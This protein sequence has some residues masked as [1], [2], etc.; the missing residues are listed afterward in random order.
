MGQFW[1]EPAD[2]A[3]VDSRAAAE[4]LQSLP[5][6]QRE[7]VV[8]RLWGGLTFQQIAEVVGV[9]ASTACRRY[10]SAIAALR[11]RLAATW[12]AKDA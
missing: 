4:A 5:E 10:E 1:F 7:V 2:D 12:E 6:E 8:A 9:S 3:T 11:K